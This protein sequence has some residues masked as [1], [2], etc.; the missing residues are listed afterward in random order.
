MPVPLHYGRQGITAPARLVVCRNPL[1]ADDRAR[2]ELL[3][4]TEERLLRV[5]RRVEAGWLK[6]RDKILAAVTRCLN[7]SKVAKH[8]F[9]RLAQ[10]SFSFERCGEHM[11]AEAALDGIYVV[12]TN[13][14]AT[15]LPA[16]SVVTSSKAL[17][18]A[19]QAFRTLKS[20]DLRIR[21]IHHWA[22]PRVRAHTFLRM[23]TQTTRAAAA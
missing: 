2:R 17:S 4:V 22:E 11:A 20:P 6:D 15:D 18:H 1:L 16:P 3:A 12:R 14:P 10:G 8:F 13:V 9:W 7:R 21:P 23:R 5:A 19:E